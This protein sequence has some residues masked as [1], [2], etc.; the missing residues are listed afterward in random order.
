MME[1]SRYK[2]FLKQG[3]LPTVISFKAIKAPALLQ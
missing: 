1:I 2:T 3:I